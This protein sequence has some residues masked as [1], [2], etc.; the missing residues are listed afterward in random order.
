MKKTKITRN[1]LF[2]SETD[3]LFDQQ[4]GMDYINQD[5]N[6]TIS[7]F[8]IDRE[9]TVVDDLYGET[10]SKGVVYHEPIE[11]NVIYNLQQSKNKTY[12]KKQNL[13]RYQQIG[14]LIFGIYLKTLKDNKTDILYGDYIGVQVTSEQ[15]EYYEIINDGK[16]DFDNKHTLFG[17]KPIYRTIECVPVDKN[18]FN[19]V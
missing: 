9:K 16:L 5:I 4:L 17:Y 10:T 11:L 2:Y 6:Q 12:D 14:N 1:N 3:F 7:L 15:M 13:A 18:V 8:K 19:G